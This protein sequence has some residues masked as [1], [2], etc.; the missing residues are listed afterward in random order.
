MSLAKLTQ[1]GDTIV[2]VL[3]SIALISLVLTSA[4]VTTHR[5]SQGIRDS[6]EHAE[7]LKLVEAQLE[8]IRANATSD[9]KEV[10]STTTPFCMSNA[11][12]VAG[13]APQ[14]TQNSSGAPTTVVPAYRLAV[15][16]AS[17]GSGALFTIT[18]T[19]DS[20]KGSRAQ[21]QI[22]YRLYP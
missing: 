14:C 16:R 6:Q 17:S 5:S 3:I 2:E 10:F 4:Y 9:A 12:P 13:S 1:R 15:N 11:L 8:Q 7:A 21:E 20:V 22:V 19:W 18:A